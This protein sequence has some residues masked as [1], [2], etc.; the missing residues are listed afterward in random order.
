MV[1]QNQTGTR[2]SN[3]KNG[4]NP[5]LFEKGELLEIA[6]GG[7]GGQWAAVELEMEGLA[8]ANRK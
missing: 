2:A 1:C 6:P 8:T 7:G 5:Q 4:K 3:D